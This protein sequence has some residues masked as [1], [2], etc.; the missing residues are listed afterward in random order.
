[1]RA[2]ARRAATI[3]SALVTMAGAARPL[4]A[5]CRTTVCGKDCDLDPITSCPTGTPVV[6]PQLCVSYSMQ[7]QASGRVDLATATTAAQKAFASWQS[8]SCPGGGPPSIHVDDKFGPV[9][10]NLH[11]YNQL[12]GN[13]NI[14]MFHDRD[15]PYS[16]SGDILALTTVTFSKK[17]GDIYDVDM[18]IN[19]QQ[20]LSTTEIVD[21]EGYD[22]QSILTHEAGHFLGL[23][24]S[25]DPLATMWAQYSA[26]TDAFRDL[27]EDDALGICAIYPPTTES[28][29][30]DFA[31]R[32]GFSPEC[33]IYPAGNGTCS[34]VIS[35]FGR[36]RPLRLGYGVVFL[37]ATAI[38]RRRRSH[39]G[40]SRNA[41]NGRVIG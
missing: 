23:G 30:C 29:V 38:A 27:S 25:L 2:L 12:D 9:A 19:A 28:N 31:P 1:V 10:C 39:L 35:S 17:S 33:G 16:D 13:A 36:R 18:E 22:L 3:L 20:P 14:I 15:W 6:W 26:G 41:K 24:H 32:Q 40:R 8:V 37:I 21:P 4:Y 11:E 5:Y 7:Y 34:L